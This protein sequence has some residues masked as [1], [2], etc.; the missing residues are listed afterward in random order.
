M[1]IQDLNWMDVARYLEEDTRIVLVTGATEQHGYLSLMTDSLIAERIA[2]AAADREGV[3]VAPPLN[4]GVS[5]EFAEFP[6]TIPL[7]KAVFEMALNDLFEGLMHQGFDRFLILN[8]HGGNRQPQH[9]VDLQME[10][11]IRIVW[12]EWRCD[13]S[14]REVEAEYNLQM[15]HANWSENFAFTR[16]ADVPEGSKAPVAASDSESGRTL[17]EILGD[18]SYGGPYQ[19]EDALMHRLF[20]QVVA[21]VSEKIRVLGEE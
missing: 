4:F 14:V 8:G 7:S 18:G 19:I 1:R 3:L 20:V 11:M 12:Y 9:L 2:L 10:N 15:N 17:G 21:E 6:G 5:S 16:V 13:A